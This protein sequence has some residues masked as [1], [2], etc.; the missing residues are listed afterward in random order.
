MR[1]VLLAVAC[2]FLACAAPHASVSDEAHRIEGQVWSPYCPGRLLIDC[3]TQQ[4]DDLRA[5]IAKR[6]ASGQSAD[7]VLRFVRLNFGDEA[8]A[9]PSG[10]DTLFVWSFPLALF[11]IG[12]PLL[13]YLLRRW[14]RTR[15]LPLTRKE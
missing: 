9:R 14:T 13:V 10:H 12:V 7:D 3:T 5:Q 15:T 11:V 1:Y 4:A 6:L 2:L 8:L